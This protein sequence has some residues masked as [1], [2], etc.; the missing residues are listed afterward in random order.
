MTRILVNWLW[1]TTNL[2]KESSG[3]VLQKRC[4]QNFPKF[5]GK[6]LC[7][8]VFFKK[9][10]DLRPA[11]LFKKRLWH[12]CFPVNFA[13]FLKIPIFKEHL[14]WLLLNLV[15]KSCFWCQDARK[16]KY[17]Y[18]SIY[19]NNRT[20]LARWTNILQVIVFESNQDQMLHACIS[21]TEM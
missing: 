8:S 10:A 20:K 19:L 11:T 9:V 18:I 17:E 21:Y 13:K 2:Q 3:S 7:Q 6:H 4:S 15:T 12:R 16:G 1:S 5:P 14:R